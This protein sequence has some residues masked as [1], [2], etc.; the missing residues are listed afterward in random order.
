MAPRRAVLLRRRRRQ[1]QPVGAARSG[2][3]DG[4]RPVP[5]WLA[6]LGPAVRAAQVR[7]RTRRTPHADDGFELV[8]DIDAVRDAADDIVAFD[9]EPGDVIAFHF[10][11][12]HAAPGTAGVPTVG[13][14]R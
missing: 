14:G 13:G 12:L 1:R 6:P 11:T 4:R 3:G 5:A 7:R 9:V 8:P 2:A 10:R